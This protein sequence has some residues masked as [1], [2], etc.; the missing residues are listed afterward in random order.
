MTSGEKKV[1]RIIAIVALVLCILV[2]IRLAFAAVEGSRLQGGAAA[3]EDFGF[4]MVL[5][6]VT[7]VVLLITTAGFV[8]ALLAR[9][10]ES[11][12]LAL[13]SPAALLAYLSVLG[14]SWNWI[15]LYFFWR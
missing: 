15:Y 1:V 5:R 7:P 4:W 6:V 10:S 2:S 11:V 12:I 13:I 3:Q 14:I 8:A 9:R